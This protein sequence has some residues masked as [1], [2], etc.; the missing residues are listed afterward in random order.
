MTQIEGFEALFAM[1][2]LERAMPRLLV[3][4]PGP[5]DAVAWVEAAETIPAVKAALW[6]YVDEL[7]KAHQIVQ[8]VHTPTG[9][10]L[11]AIVHRREGD[12]WNSKYWYRQ[13]G[14]H[15]VIDAVVHYEPYDLVDR[16]QVA[17]AAN[18]ADLIA[19]Q[20][21]EWKAILDYAVQEGG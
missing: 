11:H 13:A 17:G 15:P 14:H 3:V 20:R 21:A 6:L 16:A 10:F 9:A 19:L 8:D 7:E 5:E 2:P 4:E 1:L 18:P 12:F